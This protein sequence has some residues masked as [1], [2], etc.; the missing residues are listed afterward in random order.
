MMHLNLL[1]C[2]LRPPRRYTITRVYQTISRKKR[3]YE[4]WPVVTRGAGTPSYDNDVDDY[5]TRFY[6]LYLTIYAT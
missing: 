5:E 1:E 4:F 2:L 3:N 6:S